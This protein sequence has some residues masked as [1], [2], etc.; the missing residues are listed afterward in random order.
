MTRVLFRALRTS[1]AHLYRSSSVSVRRLEHR[2]FP[3]VGSLIV[4]H[5]IRVVVCASQCEVAVIGRQPGVEHRRDGY[6]TVTKN[7][8]A[9]RLL[10]AMTGV[11][12]DTDSEEAFVAPWSL[13]ISQS[14]WRRPERA[15]AP[16]ESSTD[17]KTSSF[18]R[19]STV[20]C[21]ARR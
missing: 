19:R 15:R 10:A 14:L 1:W 12:F 13:T 8:R 20:P 4:A 2:Q 16:F 17:S 21:T 11:A 9:R 3:R 5:E 18:S 6:T 7:Q